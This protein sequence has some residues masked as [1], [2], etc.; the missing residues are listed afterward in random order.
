MKKLHNYSNSRRVLS[1]VARFVKTS[2]LFAVMAV[3]TVL[4]ACS[5]NVADKNISIDMLAA[6]NAPGSV[7][8]SEYASSIEY[9]PLE[10]KDSSYLFAGMGIIVTENSYLFYTGNKS[11]NVA[12]YE[13]DKSGKYVRSVGNRG[14][15]K[16]EFVSKNGLCYNSQTKDYG[17][18]DNNKLL[19]YAHDGSFRSETQL[20]KFKAMGFPRIYAI[21]GNYII[22]V[23]TAKDIKSAMSGDMQDM[24]IKVDKDGNLVENMVLSN[25]ITEASTF[26][27]APSISGN[28]LMLYSNGDFARL[29]RERTTDTIK[30]VNPQTFE[31]FDHYLLE[32]S[33]KGVFM[34]PSSYMENNGYIFMDIMKNAKFFPNLDKNAQR[35]YPLLYD[36]KQNKAM[37]IATDQEY[38]MA[39][40]T[41]DIDS[42]A[43]FWPTYVSGNRM[44]KLVEAEEF[45]ELAAKSSS[46]KIKSVAAGLNIE[47]NP[48]LVVV[49]LK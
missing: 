28:G 37:A 25:T 8:L 3:S 30:C 11:V 46:D 6:V 13:Y 33:D 22:N 21:D 45:I 38:A 2:R 48:V 15:A 18:L 7:N 17:L 23:I 44:F 40:M 12:F 26:L 4:F 35:K 49:T 32:G 9:I 39:G 14:R 43:P 10:L 41:N 5:G 36:K 19:I 29:Y 42:G 24:I 16:G 31:S 20:F 27:G 47:S 34:V 1:G